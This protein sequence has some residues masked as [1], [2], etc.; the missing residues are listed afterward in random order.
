MPRENTFWWGT[1]NPTAP[2]ATAPPMVMRR[3][4]RSAA[5]LLAAQARRRFQSFTFPATDAL[6]VSN[7]VTKLRGYVDLGRTV[8]LTSATI[9]SVMPATWIAVRA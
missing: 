6:G 5:A 9:T 2:P 3:Q 1:M 8:A 4:S 7:D